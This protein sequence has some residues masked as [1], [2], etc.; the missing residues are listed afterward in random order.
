MQIII[1]INYCKML[2]LTIVQFLYNSVN[3]SLIKSL[4]FI[5]YN[6]LKIFKCIKE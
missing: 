1:Y 3:R 5:P 2:A 4:F 6:M